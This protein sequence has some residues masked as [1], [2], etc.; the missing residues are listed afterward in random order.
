MQQNNKQTSFAQEKVF[1]LPMYH[2]NHLIEF[3]SDC[4]TLSLKDLPIPQFQVLC[5]SSAFFNYK[6]LL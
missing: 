5:S 6:L 2:K 1:S 3:T 4:L